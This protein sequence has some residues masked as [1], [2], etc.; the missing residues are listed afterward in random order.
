MAK[1]HQLNAKPCSNAWYILVEEQVVTG[2]KQGHGPDMGSI[3]W[4]SVVE[5]KLGIRGNKYNPS[6][7]S[8]QWCKYIDNNY[9]IKK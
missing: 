4:R 7:T 1:Q 5:F 9:I 8:R 6:L 2:D 3:E